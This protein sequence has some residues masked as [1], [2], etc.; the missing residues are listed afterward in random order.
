MYLKSR[1]KVCSY[2]LRERSEIFNTRTIGLSR[3][4]GS[5]ICSECLLFRL[6]EKQEALN[7]IHNKE[8]TH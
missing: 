2:C 8:N 5:D 6:R 7:A 4:F 1:E 3:T